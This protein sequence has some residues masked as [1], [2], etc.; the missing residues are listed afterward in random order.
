MLQSVIWYEKYRPRN[1]SQCILPARTR[2]ILQSYVES[3]KIPNLIFSGGPGIG[4]TATARAICEEIDSEYLLINSSLEG[5]IDTLRNKIQQFAST[6]SLNGNTKYIILDEADGLTAATQSALRAFIDE[7]S[8][9]C[10]FIFTCNFPDKISKPI[11]ESR[12]LSID[13]NFYGDDRKELAKELH[14][15]SSTIMQ[16]ENV[17][18]N[19]KD[20][21]DFIVERLNKSS[22]LRQLFV[23]LQKG[24][25]SGT[26]NPLDTINIEDVR[27][28]ELIQAIKQKNFKDA[29]K[30]IG[31]N[32]DIPPEQVYRKLY[33]GAKQIVPPILVG[34][35]IILLAKYQYQ[36]AFVA[37]PEI[38]LAACI[39]EIMADCIQ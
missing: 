38:N 33:D 32:A 29:R 18:F 26:F 25:Q 20:L 15:R 16:S 10:G 31:E 5:N 23:L 13:F 3:K 19:P 12:L 9:N 35:L 21:A 11:A 39:V 1:L 37:D 30:W 27:F 22:D 36:H 2:Q 8:N 6:I 34:G 4:K 17:T 14:K 7:F 24:S 28:V